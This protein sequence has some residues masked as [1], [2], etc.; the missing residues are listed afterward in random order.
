MERIEQM[1]EKMPQWQQN[2]AIIII[3]VLI[4]ALISVSG[5]WKGDTDPL[6]SPDVA[7]SDEFSEEAEEEE[8]T[9]GSSYTPPV[10]NTTSHLITINFSGGAFVAEVADTQAERK[11]GLSGRSGLLPGRGMLFVFPFSGKH[12]IWMKDMRFPIDI[13]WIAPNG[14]IVDIKDEVSPSTY[15]RVFTPDKNALYVLEL[16][17]GAVDK[18]DI[19]VGQKLRF[20]TTGLRGY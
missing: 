5:L 2:L 12:G 10:N 6:E 19:K 18:Q 13:V 14:T 4:L 9:T 15:P 3:L 7:I 20:D 1:W 17:S 8:T 11:L 16:P